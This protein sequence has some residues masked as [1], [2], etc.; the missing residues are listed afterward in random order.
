M[1]LL[2]V[3]RNGAEGQLARHAAVDAAARCC[4]QS[5][6]RHT[7][8]VRPVWHLFTAWGYISACRPI[9]TRAT[10]IVR[11]AASMRSTCAVASPARTSSASC[12]RVKPCANRSACVQ[13]SRQDASTSNARMRVG[14]GARWRTG[15]VTSGPSCGRRLLCRR[16]AVPAAPRQAS[17][18]L[19]RGRSI[20]APRPPGQASSRGHAPGAGTCR[21]SA[22]ESEWEICGW[23][24]VIVHGRFLSQ[25]SAS[26]HLSRQQ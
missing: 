14:C 21:A 22:R 11:P 26:Q 19:S 17:A 8:V 3:P 23:V 15:L 5:C 1:M 24:T 13:P 18:R 16:E 2:G 20:S 7:L 10:S 9:R 12:G 25:R 4:D 6:G